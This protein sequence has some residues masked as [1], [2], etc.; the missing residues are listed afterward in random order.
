MGKLPF[1]RK[2]WQSQYS[3]LNH[4]QKPSIPKGLIIQA[5]LSTQLRKQTMNP[6]FTVGFV[7]CL[8]DTTSMAIMMILLLL[9]LMKGIPLVMIQTEV[10]FQM[11]PQMI[12]KQPDSPLHFR[13]LFKIV[14]APAESTS[15]YLLH[16]PEHYAELLFQK[17][18][19]T[20]HCS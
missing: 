17:S 1:R 16:S 2:Y 14:P 11:A 6:S 12:Q 3:L 7:I 18:K 9:I 4:T 13:L 10:I 8:T 19:G 5:F 15:Y 20:I